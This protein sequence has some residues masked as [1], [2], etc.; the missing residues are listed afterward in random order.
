MSSLKGDSCALFVAPGV[1]YYFEET[2]VR[3]ILA[4]LADRFPGS[5]LVFDACSPRGLKIANKRVIEN[6][7]MDAS[8]QLKWGISRP[9]ETHQWDGRIT[10]LAEHRIFRELKGA[11]SLKKKW[12]AFLS[13]A[14]RIMSMIHLRIGGE[15]GEPYQINLTV[16]VRTLRHAQQQ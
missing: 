4:K 1:L 6:G 12:G 16:Q 9:A 7:G 11:L 2:Q 13:D 14:L 8:A 10:V 3:S 15:T 5:E